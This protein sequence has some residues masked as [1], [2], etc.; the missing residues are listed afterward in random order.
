MLADPNSDLKDKRYAVQYCIEKCTTVTP[1]I[2]TLIAGCDRGEKDHVQAAISDKHRTCT[3]PG[4][5]ARETTKTPEA[6]REQEMQ[7]YENV[8]R[9]EI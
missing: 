7:A 2:A 9:A 5:G 6:T 1:S 3:V 4:G 8:V